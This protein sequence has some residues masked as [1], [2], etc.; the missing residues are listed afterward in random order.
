MYYS[1]QNS[2]SDRLIDVY[3]VVSHDAAIWSKPIRVTN[4]S[5]DRPVTNPASDPYNPN[6]YMGTYDNSIAAAAPGLG[7]GT[8]HLSWSDNRLDGDPNTPGVQPDPDIR[9][10][11]SQPVAPA[12][13]VCAYT[14]GQAFGTLC[15]LR[16][17]DT[18][19]QSASTALGHCDA[20]L[21]CYGGAGS[22]C[23]VNLIPKSGPQ[24]QCPAASKRAT[25]LKCV[26]SNPFSATHAQTAH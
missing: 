15:P 4:V 5:F 2:P 10:A 20:A 21:S 13:S 25:G 18:V 6:C 7:N 3:Q 19:C 22:F 1:T 12:G 24:P 9:V 26:A 8:F 11:V 14:V 16:V 23:I 17:G